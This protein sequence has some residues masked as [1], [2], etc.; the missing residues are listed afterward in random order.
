MLVKMYIKSKQ[1]DKAKKMA[2]KVIN[3][4]VKVESPATREMKLDIS[5]LL[6]TDIK[7]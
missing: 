2:E 5:R 4:P 1:Y 7:R 6:K 3:M